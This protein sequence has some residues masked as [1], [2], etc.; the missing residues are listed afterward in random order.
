MSVVLL[1]VDKDSFLIMNMCS[2]FNVAARYNAKYAN[3]TI[4]EVCINM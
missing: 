1:I 4:M 3:F 2:M